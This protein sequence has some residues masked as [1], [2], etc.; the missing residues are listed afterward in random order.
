MT[1]NT[2]RHPRVE[3]CKVWEKQYNGDFSSQG[4]S[5]HYDTALMGSHI[6]NVG[7]F[8]DFYNDNVSDNSNLQVAILHKNIAR[9]QEFNA[10]RG[11]PNPPTLY[12]QL[13]NVTHNKSTLVLAY[14]CWLVQ[15]QKVFKKIKLCYLPVG[16]T[17]EYIDQF[18]SRYVLLRSTAPRCRPEKT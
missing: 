3:G 1:K 15:S 11:R 7:F 17:H 16:H 13:D 14:C 8:C 10:K 5:G 9:L 6:V 12:V 18:F 2:T 4:V